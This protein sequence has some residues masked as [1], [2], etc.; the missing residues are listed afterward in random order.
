MKNEIVVNLFDSYANDLYRFALSYVGIKQEA[1]DIVQKVFLKL[2]SKS[3]LF[4]KVYHV[5]ILSLIVCWKI[6]TRGCLY[7]P[8]F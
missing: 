8:N 2:L 4:R 1:E 6:K 3:I 7:R 5:V